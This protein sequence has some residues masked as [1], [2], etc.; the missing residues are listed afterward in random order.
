[1]MD[2]HVT[3]RVLVRTNVD[4][5]TLRRRVVDYFNPEDL[6]GSLVESHERLEL[7]ETEVRVADVP[8]PS[9]SSVELPRGVAAR[10]KVHEWAEHQQGK[11]TVCGLHTAA[12]LARAEVRTN[13]SP[14]LPAVRC[15]NCE[16]MRSA[17]GMSRGVEVQ[18]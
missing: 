5:A 11:R 12:Q 9:E 7:V 14:V 3:L 1:M 15:A 16:R 6:A 18:S 8:E 17:I 10:T 13:L 4:D 2:R